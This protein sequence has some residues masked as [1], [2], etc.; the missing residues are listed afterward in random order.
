MSVCWLVASSARRRSASAVASDLAAS[1]AAR[2]ARRRSAFLNGR[3]C[4]LDGRLCG[5]FRHYWLQAGPGLLLDKD[6]HLE[7]ILPGRG[8]CGPTERHEELGSRGVES[9]YFSKIVVSEV[10]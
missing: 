7:A 2:A 3:L 6:Q 1:L 9:A 5:G 10:A 4:F 8:R